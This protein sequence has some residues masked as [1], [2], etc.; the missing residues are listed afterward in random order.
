MVIGLARLETDDALDEFLES[1]T[2]DY[3]AFERLRERFPASNLDV[4]LAVDGPDL[5]SPEHLQQMQDLTFD[6]LLSDAVESV[7]SIYS[8]REPLRD[9]GLPGTIIPSELPL[10]PEAL[11]ALE[12]RL[13]GHP[14]AS[15]R[16][17]SKS[18]AGNR[19]A[20]F[21]VTLDPDEIADRGLP[22]VMGEL[23]T[24]VSETS[25]ARDLHVVTPHESSRQVCFIKLFAQNTTTLRA[26]VTVQSFVKNA[27]DIPHRMKHQVFTN[28]A[29]SVCQAIGKLFR[30][31]VQQYSGCAD[32][33]AGHDD[34]LCLLVTFVAFFIVVDHPISHTIFAKGDLTDSTTCS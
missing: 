4:Y 24:V 29:T 3:Q 5:L 23:K 19:L 9:G 2:P 14:L 18:D 12:A 26:F 1:A 6:L 31:G 27:L 30:R 32:T 21:V 8:L 28:H 17:L 13:D 22:I 34:D 33:I 25:A 11:A 10:E 16:L 15:G 20:L 7:M